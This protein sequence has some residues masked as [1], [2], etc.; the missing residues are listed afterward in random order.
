VAD[1]L[2]YA[3]VAAAQDANL[4]GTVNP[5]QVSLTIGD[6]CGTASVEA[7]IDH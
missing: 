3:L 5:V 2:R 6:D 7:D 1:S 4:T